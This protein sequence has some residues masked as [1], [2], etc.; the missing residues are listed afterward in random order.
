MFDK[1]IKTCLM[2]HANR[3]CLTKTSKHARLKK[4]L[5]VRSNA[6]GLLTVFFDCNGMVHHKFLP[7]V[8][9]F[10]S[11]MFDKTSKHIWWNISD[12]TCLTKTCKTEKGSSSSVE[13]EGFAHC[14]L[15]LLEEIKEKLKQDVLASVSRIGKE[16]A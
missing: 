8:L 14:F 9:M 15:R 12:R 16:L 2:E 1:N 5:K 3:T 10:W 11:N 13:C 7:H 6:K 4:A